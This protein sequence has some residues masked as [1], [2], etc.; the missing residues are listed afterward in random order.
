LTSKF[1]D[2]QDMRDLILQF[3]AQLPKKV[4]RI[5]SLIERQDA[6]GLRQLVHQLK[7]AGG[8]Y[9]FD[10]ITEMAA[11]AEAP[12]KAGQSLQQVEQ[13]VQALVELLRSVEGYDRTAEADDPPAAPR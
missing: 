10:S 4:S 6:Q 13:E 11:R 5:Q 9:G 7:G 1:R 3:V 12:L 2:E 8:G